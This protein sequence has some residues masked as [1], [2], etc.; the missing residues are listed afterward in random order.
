MLLSGAFFVA[1]TAFLA[2]FFWARIKQLWAAYA[3]ALIFPFC[4]AW[5]TYWL[6]LQGEKN[7]SEFSAWFGVV[8]IIWLVFA[9]PIS[10]A[11]TFLV[12]RK[13][14]SRGVDVG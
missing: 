5:I 9:L 4:I 6:P 1:F 8:A 10:L 2:S 3:C 12:R 13:L 7:T 14:L 11:T